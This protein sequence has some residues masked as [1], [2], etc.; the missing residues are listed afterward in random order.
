MTISSV[1]GGQESLSLQ[2]MLAAL[3]GQDSSSQTGGF[4]KSLATKITEEFDADGDGSLSEEE[5]AALGEK[6]EGMREMMAMMQKMSMGQSGNSAEGSGGK[7][8]GGLFGSLMET[9]ESSGQTE[10]AD[11]DGD[12]EV[13]PEELMDYFGIS[14]AG[15]PMGPPPVESAFG[16]ATA[17]E[18]GE[19]EAVSVTEAAAAGAASDTEEA[20]LN[21]DGVVTAEEWAE[22]YGAAMESLQGLSGTQSSQSGQSSSMAKLLR[23]AIEAYNCAYG[24]Q[25]EKS[26]Q[27]LGALTA[28]GASGLNEVA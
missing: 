2:E 21:E 5:L 22:F 23:Q 7:G 9:L 11:A 26:G 24:A 13:S 28:L 15:R 17:T 4:D 10:A 1:G 27:D 20:D 8:D 12:G 19:D 14:D 6:L 25:G 3:Q 16:D 18:G